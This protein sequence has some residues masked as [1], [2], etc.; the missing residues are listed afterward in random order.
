MNKKMMRWQGSVLAVLMAAAAF[1]S[2]CGSGAAGSSVASP[3]ASGNT[4]AQSAEDHLARIK[5]AGKLTVGLEGDWQPFSYHNDQD[6]LVGYDVE[7]AKKIAEKLGVEAEIV[8]GP[9]DGLFAGM[10]SG[11]YDIVVNGVD[12]T[13][14][15]SATY[16]FSDPYAYDHTVLIVRD[17]NTDITSFEDLK[18]KKTANS[19]GSTYQEIGEQYGAEVSGVDTLVETLQ[20]VKNRQVDATINASTAFGDYMKYNPDDPLKITATMDTATEYGIPME[21]GD[22]NKSL[23][24][25]INEALK[26]LREEGT[27]SEISV[28]YFGEDLTKNS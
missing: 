24:D 11:R 7:T 19:I 18:G 14:E 22:D 20:M 8:E 10:D 17:D 25:A 21:K 9:W 27:L 26:E 16:D 23:K 12:I 1:M 3:A 2:G 28:R 15:R 5:K 6:E 4:E 13:P